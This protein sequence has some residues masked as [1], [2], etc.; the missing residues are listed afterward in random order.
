M[1]TEAAAQMRAAAVQKDASDAPE[2]DLNVIP[3][4]DQALREHLETM[5]EQGA[6][7]IQG[8]IADQRTGTR[9]P[10]PTGDDDDASVI[11]GMSAATV[12]TTSSARSQQDTHAAAA[13]M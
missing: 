3:L 6:R 4:T 13:P 9:A 11:S 8:I 7:Q 10:N 12:K 5:S 2:S 1:T